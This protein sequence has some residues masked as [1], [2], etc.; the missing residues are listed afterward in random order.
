MY[1]PSRNGP[2]RNRM[3]LVFLVV[4]ASVGFWS[5]VLVTIPCSVL[6]WYGTGL[7]HGDQWLVKLIF[8]F[9]YYRA[10]FVKQFD[11]SNAL[12]CLCHFPC[13]GVV[14]ALSNRKAATI[15][16]CLLVIAHMIML[17]I[18]SKKTL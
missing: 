16:G 12:L 18:L 9:C 14:I 10:C 13:Y 11:L 4:R 17:I 1:K 6:G 3:N 15:I 7:G 8:P 5:G 2:H